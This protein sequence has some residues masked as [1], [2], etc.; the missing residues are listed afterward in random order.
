VRFEVIDTGIGINREAAERLFQP[1]TQAD[2]STTRKF[3]GTG[4]GLA[5]CKGLV[6]RMGGTIGVDSE[7]GR[8]STFWF[9]VRLTGAARAASE[10]T[11]VVELGGL[12][13]LVVDDNG[14]NR[15]ILRE[16]LTAG[17]LVVTTVADGESA[18]EYLGEATLNGWPFAVA[19]LDMHM[20]G[21]DGLVLATAIRAEPSIA[22]TPLVLLT[23]GGEHGHSD[24]FAAVLTKPARPAQLLRI[25]ASV[26][27][28]Q[29]PTV[30]EIK[31]APR[32][33]DAAAP[34]GLTGPLVLV[35][36]DTSVNQLVARR[37][38]EKLGCR[39]DIVGNGREAVAALDT[40]PYGVIFMDVQM[41][42]MDGF[43]AT[44]EIRRRE[45][46]S[47][48]LAHT[49]IIAMTANAL[50]GDQEQCL[51][52]G[53]DDYVSKPVRLQELEIVVRRWIPLA[54]SEP[55]AA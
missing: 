27:G 28:I 50:E 22:G 24:L 3:G 21:M 17:G 10:R 5:I 52:A 14:S 9:T 4:L 30:I 44:G 34:G 48:G 31:Q 47:P 16:Q 42:E 32:R 20:P 38:L 49:T 19:V 55:E 15:M 36:E 6:E 26:L 33:A 45:R 25:L 1:F 46:E 2:S 51:A 8:G 13:V 18:L 40:I 43:E 12:R 7:P 37:M 23:S 35:A 29:A 53:M 41:P 54:A 11:A 39:V